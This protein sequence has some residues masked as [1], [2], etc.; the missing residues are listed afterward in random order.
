[1]ALAAELVGPLGLEVNTAYAAPT[2]ARTDFTWASA[3]T[4]G[5]AAPIGLTAATGLRR[6]QAGAD[7]ATFV[8]AIITIATRRLALGLTL[9]GAAAWKSTEP[10]RLVASLNFGP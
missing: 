1:M 10:R 7:G 3:A 6:E 5:L 9:E 2:D 4:L 8:D